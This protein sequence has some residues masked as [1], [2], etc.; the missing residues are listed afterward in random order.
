M[1]REHERE[2]RARGHVPAERG[3]G[4]QLR[5]QPRAPD[6]TCAATS[7]AKSCVRGSVKG[8]R[9]YEAPQKRGHARER[10]LKLQ[11]AQAGAQ[12]ARPDRCPLPRPGSVARP[13]CGSWVGAHAR[14]QGTQGAGGC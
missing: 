11:R 5:A 2:L 8:H 3:R 10:V 1:P 7:G 4:E 13:G 6:V 12:T 14:R 9:G